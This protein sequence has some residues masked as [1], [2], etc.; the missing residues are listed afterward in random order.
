MSHFDKVIA[1]DWENLPAVNAPLA[2]E[3]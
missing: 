2:R 1:P 3:P